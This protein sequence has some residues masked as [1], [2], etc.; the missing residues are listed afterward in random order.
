MTKLDAKI[1]EG[2]L[3]DKWTN[4]K[5]KLRLV[6]PA[7]RKKIDIIVVGTGLAGSSAASTLGELGYNVK[8]FCYQ[9]SPRRAHSVA[10]QGGINAAKNYKN[11]ND[12]VYRLFYDMIK[13]GDYRAREANVYR[14]AEVSNLVIDHYTAL[15]V[16]FARDYGGYIDNRSFGGVQV[17]RTFYAKGQTGQQ[18]QIGAYSA[19]S[20]QISKGT[21]TMYPRREMMDLVVIDGKARG[22]VVRNLITGEIERHSAHAV[23]LATGGYG[24]IYYL[25]TL[26][27][28]SNGSA[29]WKA[30]KKGA[31]FANPSFVQIHPTSIP[32]LNDHQCKLTLMS[33]SLRNDG[34]VWVPKQ[35]GDTR[36]PNDI[37]E[38][39]RDY[40][41]ERRYPAFGNLVPRDVASRAAK[42]RC[43][44]GYGV[45]P[46]GLSVYLDFKDA[47]NKKGRHV[48]EDSYGNLFDM[49]HK[50]TGESPYETP[51][52]IY[53][54]GHYTMGGLWVDYN[55]MTTVPGLFAIGEANFSDHGANR[56]GASSLMQT[57]GDGYFILP[58]TIADY[59]ADEIKTPKIATNLPQFDEAEKNA[60]ERINKF[61]SING[62]ET[63]TSFHKRLGKIMWD[64][65]GMVRNEEGLKKA[66]TL[67]DELQAEFWKNLKVPG[68]GE[69]LN[70][71]LEKAGRVADFME[72]GKLLV[73]DALNRK[74]SCGAHFREESQTDTGEAK[75]N[76]E[77]YSYVAAWEFNG[78]GNEPQLHKEELKFEFVKLQERSYK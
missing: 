59:L 63:A 39:E 11:D 51:M 29:A 32:V 6:N 7:N 10:A 27:L 20:R 15:G 69:E 1:P 55:L 4:H 30:F 66:L 43:D 47:I 71:E 2:P 73:Y 21:V 44:A 77:Q 33:E 3:A 54:A 48:I 24:T 56:L 25:S 23:V 12:S 58:Y 70:Q 22:I 26:A 61:L 34:R 18:C 36:K 76:D 41:L 35:K 49:Y 5:A 9:D 60:R 40:Y 8:V 37:P 38:D 19:L 52:R 13:G 50:I 68:T 14:A 31:Y 53:P 28:N 16:P 67:I 75:R 64:Y 45:G 74:E 78:D 46:T 65:C 72:L 62:T 57:S 17:S 42:E